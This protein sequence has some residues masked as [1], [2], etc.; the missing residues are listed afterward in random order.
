MEKVDDQ[1]LLILQLVEFKI[2]PIDSD[3]TTLI[4]AQ[5]EFPT[6]LHSLPVVC[7]LCWLCSLRPRQSSVAEDLYGQYGAAARDADCCLGMGEGRDE[8]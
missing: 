8:S 3:T 6:S 7:F 4:E 5:N 1:G 2:E